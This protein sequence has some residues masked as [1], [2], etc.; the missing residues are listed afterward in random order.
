M[1][2]AN[3]NGQ[4]IYY[5]DSGGAGFPVVFSH[6]LLMDHAMFMAQVQALSN[7][8]RCIACDERGHGQTQDAAGPFSYYDSADD[9]AALLAHLGIKRAV[10]AG[11]SQGGYLSLRAALKYP[12]M[13]QALILIDTQAQ[14][15]DPA[16]LPGYIQMVEEWAKHGLSDETATIIEHIIL[17]AGFAGAAEWKAKWKQFR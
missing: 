11:M 15:E 4:S 16:K 17:G 13:V 2:I 12:H 1:P 9:L 8:Y 14:P 5:E 10:L 7:R 3:I 6:G